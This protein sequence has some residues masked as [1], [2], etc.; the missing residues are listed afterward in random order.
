M[1]SI[2]NVALFLGALLPLAVAAPAPAKQ[3]K[4]DVVPNKYIVTLKSNVSA[5]AVDSHLSW[6]Q[7]THK[8]SLAKRDTAGVEKNFSIADW[9]AYAGEF[10]EATLEAIRANPDVGALSTWPRPNGSLTGVD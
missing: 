7:D 8:R 2:R 10:D 9:R 4:R 1:A 5:E 3:P 6:V